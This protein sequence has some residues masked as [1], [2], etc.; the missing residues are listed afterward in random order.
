MTTRAGVPEGVAM[1]ANRPRARRWSGPGR[2]T[3]RA[4][5]G[6]CTRAAM[7]IPVEGASATVRFGPGCSPAPKSII[8]SGQEEW[9]MS[10]IATGVAKMLPSRLCRAAIRA[11]LVILG[12][13]LLAPGG[14]SATSYPH[15][16]GTSEQRHEDIRV[17]SQWAGVLARM[18]QTP[19]PF[20][21]ACEVPQARRCHL[22]QWNAFLLSIQHHE[23]G[24]Q[25]REVNDFMNKFPYV[26]DIVNWG[27]ADFWATPLEFLHKGGECKD[28]AVAKYM[29]L[30]YLDWPIEQLRIVV[31]EDLNLRVWHA[32]LVVYSGEQSVA[33][34]NQI[35]HVVSTKNI[36]HYRPVYSLNEAYWW[37]HQD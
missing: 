11:A 36:H 14:A 16:F 31:L 3:L 30:R 27:L 29:S 10:T 7:E 4:L 9:P 32:I 35:N 2:A 24:A 34:D 26:D 12:L 22:L 15:L 5:A 8:V 6:R 37:L 19:E 28:Y 33:L 17:F 1:R 18:R 20:E 25:L 13:A 23:N 21:H